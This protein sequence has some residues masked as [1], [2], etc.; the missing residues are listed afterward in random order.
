[1]NLYVDSSGLLRRYLQRP[2]GTETDAEFNAADLLG[3]AAVTRVEVAASVTRLALGK[4]ISK[5]AASQIILDLEQDLLYMA[6]VP[7]DESV[8]SSAYRL[9]KQHALKGYD[10]VQ[11]GAAIIW[12]SELGKP[13]TVATFDNQLWAAAASEGLGVW[14]PDLSVF[15]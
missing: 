8:L 3:T 5:S 1:M 7:S 15:K 13:V 11:L 9:G 6:E 14:P 2:G 12:Q 10:A 4:A